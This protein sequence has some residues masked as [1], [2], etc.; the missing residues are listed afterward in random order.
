M[1]IVKRLDDQKRMIDLMR[2][3][4]EQL[5]LETA[6]A[7]AKEP[8]IHD[9]DQLVRSVETALTAS[10]QLAVNLIEIRE[11]VSRLVRENDELRCRIE[12]ITVVLGGQPTTATDRNA[13]GDLQLRVLEAVSTGAKSC[14]EISR[15]VGRSREH[16]SRTVG[17]MLDLG[18]VMRKWEGHTPKYALTKGGEEVLRTHNKDSLRDDI[19]P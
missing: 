9:L 16:T 11:V 15:V 13:L 17:R 6:D 12:T 7:A 2:R 4:L 5:R 1:G 14:A 8:P 19:A 3:D 18:M 10:R